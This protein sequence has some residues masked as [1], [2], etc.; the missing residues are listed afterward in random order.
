M[1]RDP[2]DFLH[3]KYGKSKLIIHLS[4]Q[5]MSDVKNIQV[6]SLMPFSL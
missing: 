3:I 4:F 6:N 1:E 5:I 2:N